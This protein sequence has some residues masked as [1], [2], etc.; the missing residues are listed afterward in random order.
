MQIPPYIA[1]GI[2]QAQPIVGAEGWKR[3]LHGTRGRNIQGGGP[4]RKGDRPRLT[5][6]PAAGLEGSAEA[7]HRI[8]LTLQGEGLLLQH[9][10]AVVIARGENATDLLAHHRIEAQPPADRGELPVG[11]TLHGMHRLM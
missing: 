6:G 7:S 8:I 11:A 9:P 2:P 4:G 3:R 10:A 5:G 1:E